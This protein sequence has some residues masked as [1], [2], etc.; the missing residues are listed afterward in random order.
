MFRIV[1]LFSSDVAGQVLA[2]EPICLVPVMEDGYWRWGEHHDLGLDM[3]QEM[4][5]LF[6]RREE[7]GQQQ[8]VPV[9]VE[10]DDLSG[11]VGWVASLEARPDG[12]YAVLNLTDKGRALLE[13]GAFGYISPEIAFEWPNSKTGETEGPVLYGAGLTNY[14]FFGENVSLGYSTRAWQRMSQEFEMTALAGVPESAQRSLLRDL[15]WRLL[16]TIQDLEWTES[17]L[18]YL[19][20]QGVDVPT[21]MQAPK[22]NLA[23]VIAEAAQALPELY[24]LAA[25][26]ALLQNHRDRPA[27]SPPDG[28]GATPHS[29]GGTTMSDELALTPE[30]QTG[31]KSFLVD[32]V[33]Y[34]FRGNRGQAGDEGNGS[35]TEE[36]SWQ[37]EELRA[38]MAQQ[39]EQFAA[40]VRERDTL[41]GRV[42]NL[43]GQLTSEQ[44]TRLAERFS[45]QA[46]GY[47]A[48]G[49]E[50]QDLA[51]HLKWLWASDDTEGK[52][53]FA[54]FE[55]LLNTAD[56]GLAESEA[57]RETGH[58]GASPNG[59]VE[60]FNSLVAQ[61][62]QEHELSFE[63][64]VA[65]VAEE[66]SGLYD[67]AYGV[68]A[69]G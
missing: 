4:V 24:N 29:T 38:G 56:E 52:E 8:R 49:A 51:G 62:Q 66:N 37:L 68:Q 13:D 41:Q 21:D 39:A 14:P 45:R 28:Q 27:G 55:A 3:I 58:G 7:I 5:A 23:D 60:R 65:K 50:V 54:Y 11:A 42:D 57:F 53:H 10:H 19:R 9:N 26:K 12:A 32:P 1:D 36:F 48:L 67:E 2:G 6:E 46:E 35:D 31:L 43:E 20:E 25:V 63:Q 61:A 40:V 64:A 33:G 18:Q 30:E 47:N 22:R 15:L 16:S 59:P 34:I 44:E 17:D 69:E